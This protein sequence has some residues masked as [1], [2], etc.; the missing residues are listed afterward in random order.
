MCFW[1]TLCTLQSQ[2][3]KDSVTWLGKVVANEMLSPN[4]IVNIRSH[5]MVGMCE[6]VVVTIEIS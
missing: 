3:N 6:E 1:T 4:S 5:R 2:N